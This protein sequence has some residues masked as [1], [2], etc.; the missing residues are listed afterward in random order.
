MLDDNQA[1]EVA[2]KIIDL[3]HQLSEVQKTNVRLIGERDNALRQVDRRVAELET[4]RRLSRQKDLAI[5]NL[6]V[7]MAEAEDKVSQAFIER[8][9]TRADYVALSQK[10]DAHHGMPAEDEGIT[11]ASRYITR[12]KEEHSTLEAARKHLRDEEFRHKALA[13]LMATQGTL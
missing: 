13:G 8:D 7:K 2:A 6:N 10:F 3:T 9:K 4:E 5:A 11:V 12:D 1:A